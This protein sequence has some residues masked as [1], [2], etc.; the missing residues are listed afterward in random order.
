M[1]RSFSLRA[2]QNHRTSRRCARPSGNLAMSPLIPDLPPRL[3]LDFSAKCNLRCSGCLLWGEEDESKIDSVNG[4]MDVERARKLLDEVA[5]AQPL[6]QPTM[7][8]EPLLIPEFR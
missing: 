5:S 1:P 8:G 7:W 2:Y 6:V 3:I 4:V